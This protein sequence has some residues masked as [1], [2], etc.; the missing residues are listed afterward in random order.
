MQDTR[1]ILL[2][3]TVFALVTA[4][5]TNIYITQPVLPVISDE[6]GINETRASLSVSAVI[7]GIALSILPFGKLSDRYAI[8]PIILVGGLAIAVSGLVC[9]AAESFGLLVVA[10][11]CQGLF[12]PSFTICLAAYLAKNLPLERLNI[13]MGGYISATVIGGLGGR[14]LGGW[15]HP[16]LHW[17]YA[18]VSSSIFMLAVVMIAM[19]SLPRERVTA[20]A[21]TL[22]VGFIS[23]LRRI[24]LLR[25]FLVSSGAFFVF[26]SIFN[27]LPYYLAGP[28]F[29]APTKII[30]LMYLSYIMGMFIGPLAGK[31][32]NRFGNGA[33]MSLGSLVFALALG[34]SLIPSIAA[35]VASLAGMCG[36]FF[37]VHAAATGALN[38]KLTASRGRANSLNVLFYYLG[39]YAGIT[40][41]GFCYVIG[42][43]T[44]VVTLGVCVLLLPFCTGLIEIRKKNQGWQNPRS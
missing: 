5:F 11:F 23:L 44:A 19:V 15:I 6:F 35:V 1:F 33:T 34:F 21:Q 7:L 20:E 18:F 8:R 14:L 40:T 16:P 27:F 42:G 2:Q 38:R 41:S 32:S 29:H 12:M 39:G 3:A 13:A 43:W 22:E 37:M 4:G 10:R 36:G 17:R 26:S 30:T 24:D 31:L 25:I 9:A 28:P